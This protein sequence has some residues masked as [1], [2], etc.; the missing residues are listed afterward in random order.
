MFV[1]GQGVPADLEIDDKEDKAIHFLARNNKELVATCRL[2]IINNYAKLER[3]AVKSDYRK[4][5][6]GSLLIDRVEKFAK[7]KN[8][9]EIKLHA[10]VKARSFYQKNN[11]ELVSDE[12]F[13]EAGIKHVEMKKRL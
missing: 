3:M 10:Q 6:V 5:G 11:Y 9:K 2:R 1:E 8:L 4:Q 12:E 13:M 7:K